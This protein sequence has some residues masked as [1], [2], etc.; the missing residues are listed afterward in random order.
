MFS[1]QVFAITGAGS[2]IGRALA[3]SL[4]ERGAQL[5]LSDLADAALQDTLAL[6]PAGTRA[7]AYRVDVAQRAQWKPSRA[8]RWP[9]SA[10]FTR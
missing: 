2:G 6:L 9:T 1:D 3:V 5:A 7:R 8:T 10:G 4:A